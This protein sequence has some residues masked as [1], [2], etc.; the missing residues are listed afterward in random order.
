MVALDRL[1]AERAG[2]PAAPS[3]DFLARV[4][5]EGLAE[6]PKGRDI[7]AAPPRRTGWVTRLGGWPALGSLACAGVAGLAIGLAAP[8]GLTGLA[9]GLVGETV[10]VDLLPETAAFGLEG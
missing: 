3:A 7:A 6:Q 5:A 1:L 9:S 2:A 4:A 10:V 8:E